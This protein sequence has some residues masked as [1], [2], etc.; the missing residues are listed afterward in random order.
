[1]N[2]NTD[3]NRLGVFSDRPAFSF[4]FAGVSTDNQQSNGSGYN[5]ANQE[6]G[7]M[8][9]LDPKTQN[10]T[11]I[12]ENTDF[13][14]IFV[15]LHKHLRETLAASSGKTENPEKSQNPENSS[16]HAKI[17]VASDSEHSV[18]TVP[19]SQ[20]QTRSIKLT[21][22]G[23]SIIVVSKKNKKNQDHISMSRRRNS[24]PTLSTTNTN[25]TNTNTNTNTN[26]SA[27]I[28]STLSSSSLIPTPT[29]TSTPTPL[30]YDISLAHTSVTKRLTA[31]A[32]QRMYMEVLVENTRSK[33]ALIVVSLR[34]M[35]Y[36]R[37]GGGDGVECNIVESLKHANVYRKQS[38]GQPIENF[39]IHLGPKKTI[40]PHISSSLPPIC[41]PSLLNGEKSVIESTVLPKSVQIADD[42]TRCYLLQIPTKQSVAIPITYTYTPANDVCTQNNT[43]TTETGRVVTLAIGTWKG[44]HL[45]QLSLVVN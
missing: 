22:D 8:I 17:S 27:P 25:I 38:M 1:M 34:D 41:L 19:R 18:I 16:S 45:G 9:Y 35:S 43:P 11:D 13:S 29:S 5:V 37:G 10:S 31:T 2:N 30:S 21:S 28:F 12:Y 7:K 20:E 15:D 36:T 40:P 26:A 14:S 33:D 23:S 42:H 4:P 3:T 24:N 32:G 6:P 39:T 44:E